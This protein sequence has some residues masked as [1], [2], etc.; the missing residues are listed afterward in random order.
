MFGIR[1]HGPGSGR[2]LAASLR[3]WEPDVVLIEGP[4][5]A[6]PVLSLAASG[7]MRPPVAL[8]AYLRSRPGRASFYPMAAWSPEWV[9]LRHALDREVPARM[10]DLPAAAFLARSLAPPRPTP[11]P[12]GPGGS[13]PEEGGW[14]APPP[15][16]YGG[17]PLA[18][19]AAAAGYD[20]T[21][22]WWE[23]VVEHRRDEE[24]WDAVVEAM[25]ALRAGTPPP[26]GRDTLTE[27]RREA[28]MRQH[29][30]AAEKTHG[31][32]AVVCGAWH[33][34]ALIERGP[35]RP[36]AELLKGLTRE[37]ATV[38]WVPWTNDRLSFTSGYGAGVAAP[39]WYEHLFVS[40]DRPVERWMVK[41]AALLRE[42]RLDAPPASVIDAVRLAETLA[43]LRGRPLAGLSEC[44]DAARAALTDGHDAT[45]HLIDRRLVVGDAVGRVPAET[46]MVALAADLAAQQRRL[47]LRPEPTVRFLELDLRLDVD[48]ARSRLLHRLDLLSVPWGVLQEIGRGTGTFRED[49]SLG[50][51]PELAVRVIE[52][53]MY[54]ATVE[55]AAANRAV[56]LAA[57]A[58]RLGDVTE[59]IERCLL[60][61]LPAAVPATMAALDTRA[62][63]ATDVSEL[64]DAV[65]PLARA[66]RYGTV[67][68]ADAGA[69]G[70]VVA[71]VVARARLSLAP[72]CASLDDDAAA[73][74][75]GRISAVAAA[76]GSLVTA[77]PATGSAGASSALPADPAAG[78][79]GAGSPGPADPATGP[80]DGPPRTQAGLYD[81]WLAALAPLSRSGS[82][83]GLVAGR[84]ARLLLDAGRLEPGE[85]ARRLSMA[86]SRAERPARGAAWVEGLVS[87][88]GLLLVHDPELLAVIDEWL[89]SVHDEAFEEVLPL[90]RRSFAGFQ[91]AER[92]M[93]GEAAA[94]LRPPG[95]SAAR[96][97]SPAAAP[98]PPPAATPPPAPGP[99]AAAGSLWSPE[100]VD[101]TRAA[102]VLP[103]LSRLLGPPA[104]AEH[105]PAPP[106]HPRV[107]PT[108]GD[109]R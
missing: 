94:R 10:I 47:R 7:D 59:L 71:G 109:H 27:A 3:A 49:W 50:W 19:L 39:G 23:D 33:A 65:V 28:A 58:T 61:D 67:R 98:A 25:A 83:H 30:R 92:R 66:L 80:P 46:P 107:R 84:A 29:I 31:R 56:E 34:P 95:G 96:L 22:R 53:S 26:A 42:E 5:E 64:M 63:L 6:A 20:D 35:A 44:T 78:S 13:L 75:T 1:H 14:P 60:A 40:P 72:A 15:P 76:L 69:L 82:V 52:A 97:D 91:P 89:G 11:D 8:L 74:M 2:A 86:L 24:P 32:V 17:D 73:A 36:D 70:R 106:E 54:G 41:V 18:L 55:E 16:A 12:A 93:I 48:L 105:P 88:S 51:E 38:T 99:P 57:G 87:G 37:K 43:A 62:A 77:G 21:E 4:P 104:P 103:L 102:A 101:E 9:A 90:L 100:D 85:V 81:E 45:L 108:T 79:G 68:R